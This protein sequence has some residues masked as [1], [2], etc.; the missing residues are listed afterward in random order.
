M[1]DSHHDL[2]AALCRENR[3]TDEDDRDFV[4]NV[5]Q[6]FL[7]EDIF[8]QDIFGEDEAYLS[9]CSELSKFG[10]SVSNHLSRDLKE[11]CDSQANAA[12][13]SYSESR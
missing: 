13:A 6:Q 5:L 10:I 12:K 9:I 4:R 7:R 8:I 3:L 11:I 2:V 1:N